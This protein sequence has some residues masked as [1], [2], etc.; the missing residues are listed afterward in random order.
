MSN[1]K[2]SPRKVSASNASRAPSNKYGL[3]GPR[4]LFCQE[5]ILDEN[6]KQAAIR[7]GFS[8]KTAAAA[9]S[10]LLT[11]VKVQRAIADLRAAR[12]DR[13]EF[14]ADHVLQELAMIAFSDIGEV[15][16]FSGADVRMR[17]A[18][19]IPERA[20]RAF[21]SIKVKRYVEGSGE[22]ARTV[23]IIEFKFCDKLAALIKLGQHLG[24]F[25]TQTELTG[26]GGEPAQ[27]EIVGFDS[28]DSDEA[29]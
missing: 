4:W 15:M 27:I 5:Y 20:R 29:S 21:A 10:R 19:A 6:G 11:N 9:S 23:E 8:A 1:K 18:N 13:F 17:D 26:P 16:D 12:N 28:V 2:K 14:D 25:K 24:M 3:T 22:E 7:A